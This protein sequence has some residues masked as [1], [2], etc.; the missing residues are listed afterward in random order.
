[1]PPESR[2]LLTD[3]RDAANEI[4]SFA[5]GKGLDE[6]RTDNL[7]RS[8]IYWQFVVI[9]EALTQLPKLDEATA[10][11]ISEF[12]RIIGFRNQIVHGYGGIDDEITWRIVERKLP[13][14][15]TQLEELLRE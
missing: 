6:F 15:R 8:G 13:I 4:G 7:L 3:V 5:A 1:M 9:G 14:L 2:K 10:T 12:D 11:R